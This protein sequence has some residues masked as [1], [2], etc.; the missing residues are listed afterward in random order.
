[1]C[2]YICVYV[3]FVDI[4]SYWLPCQA[5]EEKE[6]VPCSLEAVAAW[7]ARKAA[8]RPGGGGGGFRGYVYIHTCKSG[9]LL[10]GVQGPNINSK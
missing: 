4:Y 5:V 6:A 10:V 3:L 9:V 2:I 8:L 1:M 7:K